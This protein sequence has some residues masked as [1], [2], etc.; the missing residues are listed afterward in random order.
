MTMGV[1]VP[2]D[3]R[4]AVSAG[5]LDVVKPGGERGPVLQGLEVRLRVGVVAGRVRPGVRARDAEIGE[6]ESD[7]LGALWSAAAG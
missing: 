2:V 7:R 3:E 1:V 4:S 6:Q 5:V